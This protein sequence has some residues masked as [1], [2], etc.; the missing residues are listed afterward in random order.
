[1]KLSEMLKEAKAPQDQI[2]AALEVEKSLEKANDESKNRRLTA[3]ELKEQLAK[4]DGFD[5]EELKGIKE[6]AAKAEQDNLKAAGKFEEALAAGLKGKDTEIETL[7]GLLGKSN[8]ALSKSLIDNSVITAIDGKAINNEQ[9]LS[10]IRGNIKMEGEVPMVMDGEG[11]KLNTKGEKMSVAEYAQDFLQNNLHLV[12][13]KGGGFDSKGNQNNT[14]NA[15]S[16]SRESFDS[17][18]PV[19][20]AA[21]FKD[22]GIVVDK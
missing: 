22:G 8:T 21:H 16:I 1:M 11:H 9:V 2:D 6:K 14:N 5:A 20:K 13:P 10:L 3:N 15:N 17:L 18:D 19:A 4:F 12:N 7:K